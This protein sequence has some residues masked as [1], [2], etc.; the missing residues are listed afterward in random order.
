MGLKQFPGFSGPQ[1]GPGQDCF[2]AA[3]CGFKEE[4]GRRTLV[5]CQVFQCRGTGC[6]ASH[7]NGCADGNLREI[8]CGIQTAA[9]E[10]I[11]GVNIHSFAQAVIAFASFVLT[12]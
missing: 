6:R 9:P 10:T 1:S 7:V 8:G 11:R 12:Q 2:R 5:S 3:A 4:G